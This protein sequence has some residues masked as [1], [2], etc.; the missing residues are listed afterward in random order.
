VRPDPTPPTAAISADDIRTQLRRLLEDPLFQSSRRCAQL[1]EY[2]VEF[3]LRGETT[4]PKERIL[5]IEVFDREPDYDTANDPVVRSAAG[6]IRKRIA[7]YYHKPGHE[8]EIRFDLPTGSY[9]LEFQALEEAT[10]PQGV[11]PPPRAKRRISPYYA[12]VAAVV[13]VIGAFGVVM[14][15]APDALDRFWSPV[16]NSK[17]RLLICV[18]STSTLLPSHTNIPKAKSELDPPRAKPEILLGMPFI[19]IND[20]QGLVSIIRYIAPQKASF[21]VQYQA[22]TNLPNEYI[23]PSLDELRKGPTVFVGGSDWTYRTIPSLRFHNK[24]DS[25]TGIIY[26]EDSQNP[27]NKKWGI[28][29]DQP[30]LSYTEDYAFITRLAD[31]MTG[32]VL[33]FISGMGLHGTGAAC[34]FVTNSA[35][36]NEVAPGNSPEWKKKNVQLVI[37][38]KVA[39][40]AWGTPQLLA[41]HFW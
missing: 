37:Y 28:R 15:R 11:Q 25:E 12:V 27:A 24:I 22:L 13:L 10:T 2:L 7:Q 32:Q 29:Q 4:S 9:I 6:E 33:V 18:N 19:G 14:L 1:L 23:Q 21:E 30:F 31:S 5:G 8:S 17:S 40:K 41:K 26:I 3:K 35:M 20:N 38:T 39:D 34:E 16:L 36:M